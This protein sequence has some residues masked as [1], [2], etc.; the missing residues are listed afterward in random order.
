VGLGLLAAGLSS[1]ITAPL[2]AAMTAASLLGDAEDPAWSPRGGRYRAVWLGVLMTGSLFGVAGVQPI[3]VI[4][5]AQALNGL[6]LP[7]VAAFLFLAVNDVELMGRDRVNSR[8]ANVLTAGVLAVACLLGL[9]G[10]LRAAARAV[11]AS[12]PGVGL[13]VGVGLVTGFAAALW[14]AAALRRLRR[15]AALPQGLV[16][17]DADA[18]REVERSETL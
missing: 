5:V 3:P 9:S 11:G 16:E 10:L 17:G 18:G 8:A 6:L 15:G 1:A 12:P 13:L 7:F 4:V 2:A 14:L